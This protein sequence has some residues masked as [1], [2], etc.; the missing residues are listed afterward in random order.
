MKRAF[1]EFKRP[2]ICPRRSKCT[3]HEDCHGRIHEYQEASCKKGLCDGDDHADRTVTCR[4]ATEE[5]YLLED[6]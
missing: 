1:K 4:P 5:D 3:C 6:F 2:M